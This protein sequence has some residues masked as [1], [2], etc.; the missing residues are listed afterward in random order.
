MATRKASKPAEKLTPEAYGRFIGQIELEKIWVQSAQMSLMEGRVLPPEG[1]IEINSTTK[2]WRLTDEGFEATHAFDLE[3]LAK[4]KR[5]ISIAVT[6]GLRYRST[7]PMTNAIFADFS[8]NLN[9][10][11][12]PYLREFVAG[13][14]GRMGWEPLTLPLLKVGAVAPTA[15]NE[16]PSAVK[17]KRRP[18]QAK[19]AAKR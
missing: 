7:T 9:V 5:L 3:A 11:T 14:V 18:P 13:M 16:S 1:N 4:G 2:G 17:T 15:E 8:F 12:W 19:K 6:F 10:N